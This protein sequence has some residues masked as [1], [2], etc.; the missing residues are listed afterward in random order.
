MLKK[1]NEYKDIDFESQDKLAKIDYLIELTE[2]ILLKTDKDNEV[3]KE[4]VKNRIASI[5]IANAISDKRTE[6]ITTFVRIEEFL[7]WIKKHIGKWHIMVLLVSIITAFVLGGI[8]NENK[9][10]VYPI[11]LSFS[12]FFPLINKDCQIER[13]INIDIPYIY[14]NKLEDI[15]AII[16]QQQLENILSTFYLLDNNKQDKLDT[17]RKN[18]IQKCI[19]W[20]TKYKLPYNKNIQQLNAFI[21]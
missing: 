12:K 7:I 3:L 11:L 20:C 21:T 15:N 19:Q 9:D 6:L 14:I 4:L 5:N 18:N 13:F 10:T 16:G 17:I 1:I 2:T 8:A